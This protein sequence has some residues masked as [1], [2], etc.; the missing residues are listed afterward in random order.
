[1]NRTTLHLH[2][3]PRACS[4]SNAYTH[5]PDGGSVELGVSVHGEKLVIWLRN[6]AGANHAKGLALQEKDGSVTSTIAAQNDMGSAESTFLGS[7][8]IQQ[9][10]DAMKQGASTELRFEESSV[11]FR[12]EMDLHEASPLQIDSALPPL[13][14]GMRLIC[15]GIA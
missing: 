12:L 4:V 14:P 2:S 7:G 3:L 11:L 6:E 10:A 8:E 5:G 9:A 1:M 13:P 15:V